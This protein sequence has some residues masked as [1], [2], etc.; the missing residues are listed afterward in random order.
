MFIISKNDA[1]G[2]VNLNSQNNIY[3]GRGAIRVSP[4]AESVYSGDDTEERFNDVKE[5][6]GSGIQCYDFNKPI[7]DWKTKEEPK[8]KTRTTRSKSQEEK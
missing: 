2:I 5:A 1:V 6:L 4:L 8:P 7:G 3:I